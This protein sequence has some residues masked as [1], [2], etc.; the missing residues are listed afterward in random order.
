MKT[1]LLNALTAILLLIMPQVNFGQSP[2][3]GTT[4][5]FAF[6]TAV[7]A[8]NNDGASVVKGDVGTNV[9]AFNA[10]PPGILI[11]AKH[12]ED[13]ASAQA[14]IDV[15][16]AYSDLFELTPTDVIS[17][18]LG[19]GQIIGPGIHAIGAA[20]TLNG[21]LILDGNGD[22]GAIFIFQIDGALATGTLS[23]VILT[24]SAS[25]CNVYWQI[26][27]Q[28]DLGSGSVFR[29]TI[30]A[31]GAIN[32]LEASSLM[33]RGLSKAGAI[34]LHN[35]KVISPFTK[36]PIVTLT[37]PTCILPTGTITITSPIGTGTTY[38]IDGLNYTNTTGIF[39][40]VSKG[41]Y[42]VTAAIEG[43]CASS[44][45]N[46]TVNAVPAAPA[47]PTVTLT[48]PTCILTTGTIKVTAPKGTG[49][50]YSINGSTYTNTTG[51]FTQLTPGTYNVTAKSADGCI[52]SGTNVTLN[53]APGAPAAP[54]ATLTQ[55]TCI[56]TTGTIKVTA[57]TGTGI[58]YSIN[59]TTYTNTT[60]LFTQ[61][62]PGTYN[63]T[64]KNADGCI[65]SGT[66]VTLN[67]S[68][69]G[70]PATPATISADG[71]TMICEGESVTLS[72]NNGGIWSNGATTP[73][74]T[75]YK[76]GDYFVTNTNACGSVTSNHI[77]VT[78]NPLPICTISY[79]VLKCSMCVGQTMH[80]SA[81]AGYAAYLWSTG[82]TTN[83]IDVTTS[84]TYYVTVTNSSG[85]ISTCSL[86]VTVYQVP[87]AITGNDITIFEG[88]S[89]K[90]GSTPVSGNTYSWSPATG[91]SSA[92]VANPT[93]SP[94]VTTTYTLTETNSKTGCQKKN[95]VTVTVKPVSSVCSATGNIS[96]QVWKNIGSSYSISKLIGN[97]NYPGNPSSSALITSM[98]APPT[99]ATAFGS[100]IAGY[101][102]APATGSYT[103]WIASD[104][105]GELW[106]STN[107]QP[108]N[109]VRI[110]Y[111]NGFTASRQWNKYPTQKSVAIN[112][113]QGQKYYIEALMKQVWGGSCQVVGW[114][115]P[116]QT[117]TVPS[118]VIPGSVLSPIG[119]VQT[120]LISSV[121]LPP[122]ASVNVGST[123]LITA[124]VLPV[125]ASNPT[126]KWT[127]SNPAI[128]TVN[129][130]G[131]VTGMSA[132]KANITATSSDGSNKSGSSL[133][134]VNAVPTI[135]SATGNISYQVWKNI[136][137]SYSIS[138]LT[139]NVNYPDN[140][141]SSALITSMEASP[142]L[143]TAFGSRIV[144]YICAPATGSYTF[145]IASDN[146]GEL[147]LSTNDQP[148]SK[149]R[150][151]YHNGFTASRQW[152]KYATQKSV[153]INLVQGQKY[154][155]E[156]LM[157]Q[158]WG[159]SCQVVGW[160][161]PGQT[162]TVPSEVI[163]ASVLSPLVLT[164]KFGERNAENTVLTMQ[165]AK[166]FI[167]PNPLINAVLNIEL[168]NLTSEATLRIYTM[169]GVKCYEEVI[170]SSGIYQVDRSVFKS[171]MY[172]IKVENEFFVK[173]KKLIV[174]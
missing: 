162:G 159:G 74:I 71:P 161:K 136:G 85:C 84:G 70:P 5:S 66:N 171:G 92:I 55:P 148:T 54:T 39:T 33:G 116:G 94:S 105:Q 103:F 132:G 152:N 12:V 166:L 170:Q 146:L 80:L 158:V 129:S 3:L 111:H 100:R 72:G 104:N 52:S 48:Q 123:V 120:K 164:N 149:V 69:G 101:I 2:D 102:C 73:S 114:L 108:T 59:G 50:T 47:A 53:A 168:E 95:S 26:N 167:Y 27:G 11:G 173:T 98:E 49:I 131:L 14:A 86:T 30:I 60:G 117:G 153:A 135:C 155:I 31:N 38:S 32:L 110:A 7:G 106:L 75:V 121:T 9:G 45:T 119:S 25:L 24:N 62:T 28:F 141:S 44:E 37:Q 43:G 145:W 174:N 93:A 89:I 109:K 156:A 112:L 91:L 88:S 99:L 15:A 36:A 130:S 79:S 13:P 42:N 165:D 1:L 4:S 51:L 17:T 157:K 56:L 16:N 125:N 126:L 23:N 151:A 41:T 10:F 34:S 57:P 67:A 64:A 150:I 96:Y 113:V 87:S 160:L 58:T 137:S 21:D 68:Q 118:E 127:T 139:G 107:D 78:V 134:T 163:P 20:A 143:A 138:S 97:V 144:G 35:N 122:T 147:W 63:V 83:Y 154:Y 90:L 76:S 169:S 6:F 140:P 124:S 65:S 128:A 81:P 22:P 133:V 18:S 172:V 142:T 77:V 40:Q 29:G 61:V 46:V 8:F 115:K 19:N 82:A